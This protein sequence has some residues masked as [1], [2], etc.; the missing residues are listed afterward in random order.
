[1]MPVAYLTEFGWEVLVLA[2]CLIASGFFSGS[3]TALFSLSRRDLLGFKSSDGWAPKATL[4]LTRHPRRL[5]NTLLLGNMLVNI[6]FSTTAA[7]L[8]LNMERAGRTTWAIAAGS[9]APL[10]CLI[11]FG[12]VTPKLLAYSSAKRWSVLAAGPISILQ[13]LFQ[14]VLWV[15]ERFLVSPITRILAPRRPETGDIT[16]EELTSV[17]R[18]SARRGVLG[19]DA[20][21]I[22][23]EIMELADLKTG[24]I[25][26][27]RIDVIAYDIEKSPEG[28]IQLFR[29]SGLRKMPV[30]E[31]NLDNVLGVVHAKRLLL[32]PDAPLRELIRPVSF[33]PEAANLEKVLKQFRKT[34]KQMAIVVDE[35][36]GT[37]GLITLED[38]LEEIV[39]DIPDHHDAESPPAVQ[40]K[41]ETEYVVSGDLGIHDLVEAFGIAPEV[42]PVS[43]LGGL[44]TLLEG[45]IPRVGDSVTYR[46]LRFTVLTMRTRRVESVLLKLIGGET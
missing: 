29:R 20:G 45:R 10:L 22:L 26:V 30:Y 46:N 34:Q 33:L 44:V 17:M 36:G 1:M 2:G 28:L 16:T 11:L 7:V 15:L 14:P 4:R 19:H 5:L 9:A 27:P 35:Y 32:C 3:E 40:K 6:A 13:R 42:R 38:V 24:D 37:A 21:A 18:L 23:Q 12:E 43:T 41:S 25:M 31:K 8:V 39:G